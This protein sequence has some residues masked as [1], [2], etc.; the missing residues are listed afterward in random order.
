MRIFRVFN[1]RITHAIR[2]YFNENFAI[3]GSATASVE[4]IK[5]L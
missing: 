4:T 1:F 5:C 2:K 3:Y